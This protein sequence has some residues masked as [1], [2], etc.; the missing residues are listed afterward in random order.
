MQQGPALPPAKCDRLRATEPQEEKG[1][2]LVYFITAR[3]PTATTSFFRG[4]GGERVTY[5]CKQGLP[6]EGRRDPSPVP[7]HHSGPGKSPRLGRAG[8]SLQFLKG[9]G[10]SAPPGPG[11]PCSLVPATLHSPPRLAGPLKCFVSYLIAIT[12]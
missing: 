10:G 5:K 9:E 4:G 2:L 7:T 6:Q 3:L 12:K 11:G 1:Q 8:H